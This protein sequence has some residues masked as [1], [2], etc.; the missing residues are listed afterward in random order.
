MDA[1]IW[2]EGAGNECSYKDVTEEFCDCVTILIV[3][4]IM[5]G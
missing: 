2:W 4:V 1:S 5:Q 3:M